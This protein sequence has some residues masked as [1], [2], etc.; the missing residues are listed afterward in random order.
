MIY[1]EKYAICTINVE[2]R[3]L[4]ND[5]NCIIEGANECPVETNK[6]IIV[7]DIEPESIQ[8]GNSTIYFSSFAGQNTFFYTV[9]IENLLKSKITEDCKYYFKFSNEPFILDFFTKDIS[10]TFNMIF[11]G[12]SVKAKCL[13]YQDKNIN[14]NDNKNILSSCYF[15]LSEDLCKSEDLLSYDLEIGENIDISM[16]DNSYN[17]DFDGLENQTIFTVLAGNI[18]NKYIENNK[19]IFILE[20]NKKINILNEDISFNLK[21]TIQENNPDALIYN[22]TCKINE[23]KNIQCESINESLKPENDI[24]FYENPN[25]LLLSKKAV[26]FEKFVGLRTFTIKGGQIQKLKCRE[27]GENYQ[28]NII[29]SETSEYIPYITSYLTILKQLVQKCNEKR[30]DVS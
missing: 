22:S 18:Q 25:Y 23:D 6:D 9:S 8:D 30:F 10:F 14:N 13:L 29:N 15:D 21:F 19:L 26:Y 11:N 20:N 24:I 27:S 28:F 16:D 4:S 7:G 5:V 2:E 12:E 17:I 1:P 3:I